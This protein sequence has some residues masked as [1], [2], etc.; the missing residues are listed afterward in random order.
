MN[1]FHVIPFCVFKNHFNI[2]RNYTSVFRSGLFPT[3]SPTKSLYKFIFTMRATD[4]AHLIVL[5]VIAQKIF[6][7]CTNPEAPSYAMQSPQVSSYLFSLMPKYL[8]Q[9][10]VVEH[11]VS[12]FVINIQGGSNMTG[13]DCV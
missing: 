10:P 11:P 7:K 5:D 6:S 12:I 9:Q 4:P 3:G 2:I 1:P 8:P 13:T